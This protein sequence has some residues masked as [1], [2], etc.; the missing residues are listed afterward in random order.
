MAR[1]IFFFQSTLYPRISQANVLEV[2]ERL[3]APG[4][5]ILLEGM[6]TSPR[7]GGVVPS[8]DRAASGSRNSTADDGSSPPGSGDSRWCCRRGAWRA[9]VRRARSIGSPSKGREQLCVQEDGYQ[10][11]SNISD[12]TH[13]L[14]IQE[15][16]PGQSNQASGVTCTGIT[17]NLSGENSKESSNQGITPGG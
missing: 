5:R 10:Y 13:V 3:E 17:P 6:P 14:A 12:H 2:D 9:A 11:K 7:P 15:P 16:E 4:R 1:K 8:T